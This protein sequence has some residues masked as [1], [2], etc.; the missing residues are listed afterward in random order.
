MS[1]LDPFGRRQSHSHKASISARS[2]KGN[3]A[4]PVFHPDDVPASARLLRLGTGPEDVKTPK[5]EDAPSQRQDPVI[6]PDVAEAITPVV[7]KF[8]RVL[9]QIFTHFARTQSKPIGSKNLFA[10]IARWTSNL[11]HASFYKVLKHYKV[12][13]KLCTKK[14]AF[15]LLMGTNRELLYADFLARLVDI[16]NISMKRLY[17]LADANS[18]AYLE[19]AFL[20]LARNLNLLVASLVASPNVAPAY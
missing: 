7:M 18:I 11:T 13:P 20:A 16:A 5:V 15:N 1:K 14:D 6:P 3:T 4:K 2:D 12:V 9:R 10:E 17:V 19:K 8:D